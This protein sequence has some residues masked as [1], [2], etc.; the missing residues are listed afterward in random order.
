MKVILKYILR[1]IIATIVITLVWIIF[2]WQVVSNFPKI[3]SS[4]YA[5]EFCS[6][7]FVMGMDEKQCH[8]FARQYISISSFKLDKE[9]KTVSVS[10]LGYENTARFLDERSGCQLQ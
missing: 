5:K 10:G 8:N 2:N 9:K 6:C 7:Y 1:V 3:I 4:F